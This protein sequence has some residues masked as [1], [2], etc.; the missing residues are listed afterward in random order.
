MFEVHF[1]SIMIRFEGPVL[2]WLQTPRS[3]VSLPAPHPPLI[4]S[5]NST[6]LPWCD[7]NQIQATLP[8]SL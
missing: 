1:Q 2:N 6:Y 4:S 3:R 8:D 5:Q 7:C